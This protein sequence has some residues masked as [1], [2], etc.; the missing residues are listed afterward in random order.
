MFL[1]RCAKYALGSYSRQ[2]PLASKTDI[3]SHIVL[4]STTLL[5]EKCDV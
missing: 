5:V 1:Q 3:N 2:L 4:Y